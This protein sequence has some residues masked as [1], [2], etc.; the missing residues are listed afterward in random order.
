MKGRLVA[1][2][3]PSGVGK[4]SVMAALEDACTSIRCVRRV[5]TRSADAEGE[6]FD[7]VSEAQFEDMQRTEAFALHWRAHGLCYGI[8]RETLETHGKG[9]SLL[10]NLSRSVLLEAQA[11]FPE[12]C[13]LHLT[14]PLDVLAKRLKARGRES[15]SAIAMRLERAEFALPKGLHNV[16]EVENT[17]TLSDTAHK[18]LQALQ[19][20]SA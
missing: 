3:G 2:V 17:G 20:E 5:V 13:V 18:A 16:I 10:V 15:K 11:L 6:D 8:P 12:F 14:A 9:L 4:D 19:L 7:A 1:V